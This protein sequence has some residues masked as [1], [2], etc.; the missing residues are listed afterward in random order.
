MTLGER[1]NVVSNKDGSTF[2]MARRN[3]NRAMKTRWRMRTA[4]TRLGLTRKE[5][6]ACR[7]KATKS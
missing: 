6:T 1:N 5:P 7:A 2:S 4:R 3:W